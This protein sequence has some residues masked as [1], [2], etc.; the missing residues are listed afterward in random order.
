MLPVHFETICSSVNTDG[1]RANFCKTYLQLF[2][3][4]LGNVMEASDIDNSLFRIEFAST[5]L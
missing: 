5:V 2:L 1:D 4:A 3:A